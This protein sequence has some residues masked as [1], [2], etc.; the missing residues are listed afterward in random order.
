MLKILLNSISEFM[1]GYKVGFKTQGKQGGSI[2]IGEFNNIPI[3]KDP[4]AIIQY[5]FKYSMLKNNQT[6]FGD[7]PV[8]VIDDRFDKFDDDIR[9]FVLAHE[10]GHLVFD[11]LSKME[12]Y[13]ISFEFQ[14]DQFAMAATSRAIAKKALE[15]MYNKSGSFRSRYQLKERIKNISVA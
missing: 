12:N 13:D 15:L 5:K 10:Q 1:Y 4:L 11:H 14:A 8:I 7:C 2:R 6:I 3:Y 9:K